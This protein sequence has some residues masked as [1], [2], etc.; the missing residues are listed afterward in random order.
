MMSG[1]V[2]IPTGAGAGASTAALGMAAHKLTSPP[3]ADNSNPAPP[4]GERVAK[5]NRL[6]EIEA[7]YHVPYG[8]T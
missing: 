3:A 2:P 5:Y 7:E 8:R 6:I 4:R 1:I